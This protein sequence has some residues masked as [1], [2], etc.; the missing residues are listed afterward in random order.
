MDAEAAKLLAEIEAKRGYVLDHHRVLAE[1]DPAFL[2]AYEELLSVA[3]T[4]QRLL[5]RREKE[6][7]FIGVLTALGAQKSHLRAHFAVADRLG[8]T[9]EEI[10]EL[11]EG[12][13]PPCGVPKFMNAFDVWREY[14][15]ED[16]GGES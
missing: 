11:L 2:R 3:Y 10:L 16:A 15:G 4:D 6:L 14:Y 7:I 5:S 1:A 9:R 13:V 12:C 8:V